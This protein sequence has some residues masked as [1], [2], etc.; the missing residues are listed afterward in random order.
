M[1]TVQVVTGAS[2]AGPTYGHLRERRYFDIKF[3][4]G[5]RVADRASCR[6]STVGSND[7]ACLNR[8]Q[9]AGQINNCRDKSFRQ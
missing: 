5:Q 9:L 6:R 8:Q 4:T 1:G 3:L 2:S 7:S